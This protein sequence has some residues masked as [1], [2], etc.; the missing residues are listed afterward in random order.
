M[1]KMHSALC[2][3][4]N[5]TY[6]IIRVR[7]ADPVHKVKP[8]NLLSTAFKSFKIF[9]LLFIILGRLNTGHAGSSGC[10]AII[11]RCFSQT[12][13]IF[14]RKYTR[15]SKQI[16]FSYILISFKQLFYMC[17]SLRLPARHYKSLTVRIYLLKHLVRVY[18]IYFILVI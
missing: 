14:F 10:I 17:Q 2:R 12:G 16:L 6:I 11:I 8:L 1:S 15:L 9:S 13:C 3:L 7:T 18:F 4:D 5:V